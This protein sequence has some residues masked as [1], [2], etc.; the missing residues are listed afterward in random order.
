[1]C[2]VLQFLKM[3]MVLQFLNVHGFT[4]YSQVVDVVKDIIWTTITI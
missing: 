3:C 1:M 4:V 2:M